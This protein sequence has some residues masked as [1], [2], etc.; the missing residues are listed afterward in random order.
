MLAE[1]SVL[2]AI[3]DRFPDP[4]LLVREGK[5]AYCNPPANLEGLKAGDCPPWELEGTEGQGRPAV[6]MGEL[7]GRPCRIHIQP[8]ENGLLLMVR[9]E[10]EGVPLPALERVTFQL[11]QEMTGL[12]AALQ[13]M[14]PQGG[15]KRAEQQKKYMA[16]ASQGLCRLL[17]LTGH[18][19]FLSIPDKELYQPAPLDLAG[20]CH[21]LARQVESVC[22][23]A[24]RTFSYELEESSLI[25]VGDEALLTRLLLDL[26]S[27]ALRAAG[28]EGTAG[29]R[30]GRRRNRAV[31]TVWNSG[32][33]ADLSRIFAGPEGTP[34][35]EP[36]AGLGLGLSA[37]RRIAALHG[38]TLMMESSP[39]KGLR[40][41][42][43]LPIRRPEEGMQLRSPQADYRGGF[44]T[45]L[46]ELSNVLPAE[47]YDPEEMENLR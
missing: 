26:L 46:V 38:G 40:A 14:F 25:T 11:R 10:P 36:G 42:L 29:L 41:V 44:P 17:R 8:L 20:F 1:E 47:L 18:L 3:F 6:L 30:L 4:V 35:L 9:A 37:A 43:S 33:E 45:L 2:Q 39:E 27:N 21:S 31:V 7:R 19:E 32:K 24:G 34:P 15:E 22:R 28:P 5:I 23:S 16:A 13:R 12:S